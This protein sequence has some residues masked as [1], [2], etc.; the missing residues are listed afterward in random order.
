MVKVG[1]GSVGALPSLYRGEPMAGVKGKSGPPGHTNNL[2]GGWK[3]WLK[4]NRLPSGPRY[5]AIAKF[6]NA[7][8]E[9]LIEDLGGTEKMSTQQKILVDDTVYA[10]TVVMLASA[11]TKE[12]GAVMEDGQV[13]SVL[14]LVGTFINIVRLNL[15]A[16]GLR[17]ERIGDIEDYG[18]WVDTHGKDVKK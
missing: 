6:T 4:H 14:K 5:K 15:M 3:Y 12:H 7:L 9:G 16:L 11:D 8:R 18:K 17:A 1:R 2:R 10:Q 13:R